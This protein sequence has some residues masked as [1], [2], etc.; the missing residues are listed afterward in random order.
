MKRPI[1]LVPFLLTLLTML[2]LSGVAESI[3][4]TPHFYQPSVV[5][6]ERVPDLANDNQLLRLSTWRLP[7]QKPQARPQDPLPWLM[8]VLSLTSWFVFALS[9]RA[10]PRSYLAFAHPRLGG[11]HESNLQF[12]FIH[13]R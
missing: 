3:G 4:E 10:I 7:P 8:L 11:W 9:R 1:K 12:R 13:S 2:L 6:P 5:N